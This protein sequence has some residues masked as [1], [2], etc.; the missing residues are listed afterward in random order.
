MYSTWKCAKCGR[1]DYGNAT[2]IMGEEYHYTP[3]LR[4][5]RS[6]LGSRPPRI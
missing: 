4:T 5:T 6:R 3:V 2:V 1:E